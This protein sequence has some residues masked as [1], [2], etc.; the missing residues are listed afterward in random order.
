MRAIQTQTESEIVLFIWN[1]N[2]YALD[3]I[4]IYNRLYPLDSES[5][6]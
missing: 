4:W 5:L 1:L 6:H 3:E 2:W